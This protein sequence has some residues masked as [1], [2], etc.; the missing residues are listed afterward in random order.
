MKHKTFLAISIIGIAVIFFHSSFDNP[1]KGLC[2]A[3]LLGPGHAGDPGEVS[4]TGC[5]GGSAANSGSA[6][7]LAHGP[8]PTGDIWAF[9]P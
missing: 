3:P 2:T 9:V 7:L 5:H 1:S 6:S 8:G 4:C